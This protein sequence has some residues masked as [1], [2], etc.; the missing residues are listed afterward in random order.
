MLLSEI[1]EADEPLLITL[2]K[3]CKQ[4]GE[5]VFIGLGQLRYFLKH[6][7]FVPIEDADNWSKRAPFWKLSFQAPGVGYTDRKVYT[8]DSNWELAKVVEDGKI[9][10]KMTETRIVREG[11]N[12]EPLLISVIRQRLRK[13]QSLF[14]EHTRDLPSGREERAR[15]RLIMLKR[16][17]D[18]VEDRTSFEFMTDGG[19]ALNLAIQDVYADNWDIKKSQDGWELHRVA[20]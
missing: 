19:R 3:R 15:Y 17:V 9:S 20:Q 11:E 13:G 12:E 4:R 1:T 5:P 14:Y 2:L 18:G 6:I 16:I 8:D 10:W 7:R